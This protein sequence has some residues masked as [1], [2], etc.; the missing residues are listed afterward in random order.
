L[1]SV[2]AVQH[3]AH[4]GGYIYSHPLAAASRKVY[5]D[6]DDTFWCCYGT[7]VEAFAR[8]NDGIF[9]HDERT[10]WVS[11]FVAS[12]VNWIDKSVRVIQETGFPYEQGTRLTVHCNAPADF[13]MKIRVPR[14][15]NGTICRVNG[16]DQNEKIVPGSFV[17]IARTWRDGDKVE[18]TLPMRVSA[19]MLPGEA[20]MVAFLYGPTVL[21]AR[22]PHGTEL[23]VPTSAATELVQAVDLAKLM[24]QIRLVSGTMVRLMP[25][26]EIV[27]EAYGVY[28]RAT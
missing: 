10:L 1:N 7:S 28:F 20:H 17:A 12:E 25:L 18:L 15:A 3:P 16:Q 26:N 21:A 13:M 24:F 9:F 4:P 14:W 11:Q 2:L 22:T 6:F 23:G 8:L 27:D 5:G 19:E